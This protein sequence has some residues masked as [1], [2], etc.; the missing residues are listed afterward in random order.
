MRDLLGGDVAEVVLGVRDVGMAGERRDV[1]ARPAP[2]REARVGP[3]VS[4]SFRSA[5]PIARVM[6]ATSRSEFVEARGVDDQRD[7]GVEERLAPPLRL[8]RDAEG[9]ER[10]LGQDLRGDGPCGEA[11]RGAAVV[12]RDGRV[13]RA[14][15]SVELRVHRVEREIADRRARSPDPCE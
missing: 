13:T 4:S 15:L 10:V 14:D 5:H 8:L 2:V 7:F 9:R 1:D 6:I 12:V 3:A 11:L